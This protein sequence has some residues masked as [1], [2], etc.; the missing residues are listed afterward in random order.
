VKK[1]HARALGLEVLMT[2]GQ[3][4]DV[5]AFR[6]L[7]FFFVHAGELFFDVAERKKKTKRE[8]KEE[9]EGQNKERRT[10]R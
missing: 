2:M 4:D 5:I 3:V 7:H 6:T 8:N 9:F 1:Y 10:E